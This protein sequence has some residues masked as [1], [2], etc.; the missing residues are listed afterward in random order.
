MKVNVPWTDTNTTYSAGTGINIT[1]TTISGKNFTGASTAADGAAGIV[2]QPK[3]A[4]ASKFLR[5]DGTWQSIP[6]QTWYIFLKQ[7]ASTGKLYAAIQT[8]STA[9]DGYT[10]GSTGI[11]LFA[12][13]AES[14]TYLRPAS[15]TSRAVTA[16]ISGNLKAHTLE[17]T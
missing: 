2:P 7:D 15:S 16:D 5:G 10:D 12:T 14:A 9:P 8:S 13:H 6:T 11:E 1:G 3:K 17:L 4:D